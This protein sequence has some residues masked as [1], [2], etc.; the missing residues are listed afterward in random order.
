MSSEPTATDFPADHWASQLDARTRQHVDFA[1][2]YAQIWHHGAPGH[3]DLM[4]IAALAALLDNWQYRGH[5]SATPT[6]NAPE[7][8]GK[9]ES[10]LQE[11]VKPDINTPRPFG[12]VPK[13]DGFA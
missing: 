4:T 7:G 6:N 8:S 9:A 1:R 11:A 2:M 5:F 10:L 12:R 3:L 13:P